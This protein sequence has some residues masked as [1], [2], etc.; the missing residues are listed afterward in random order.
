[1]ESRDEMRLLL[2]E[3]ERNLADVLCRVL[4]KHGY[5]TDVSYNGEDGLDN[6]MS[7]IYDVI[8]LDRM[9]PDM[10]G[11]D[12]IKE[13]RNEGI[14]TP[15]IFLTALGG[16]A[17][18][19]E[20]LDSGADDYLAKPFS[21]EELLARIRALG[22]RKEKDIQASGALTAGNISYNPRLLTV[23]CED[24][25]IKLTFK[26]AQIL[27]LLMINDRQ[28]LSKDRI[29][30][31]VWG[32]NADSD[33]TIVEIYIHHLRKKISFEGSGIIIETVRGVGYRLRETL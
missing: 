22:R 17:D 30:D 27:E 15:V 9:L 12:V 24:R 18:K 6:A 1:M 26:E 20:G 21:N 11:I 31:K 19:V 29:Y 23:I 28:T 8:L 16:I 3:D 4:K 33:I 10:N 32:F 25:E 7:G 2:V 14:S 13:I 5:E